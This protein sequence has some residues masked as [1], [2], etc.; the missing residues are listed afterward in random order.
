MLVVLTACVWL[1]GCTDDP[2]QSNSPMEPIDGSVLGGDDPVTPPDDPGDSGDSD[3]SDDGDA[4]GDPG[5]KLMLRTEIVHLRDP[6]IFERIRDH[7]QAIEYGHL[8]IDEERVAA[9]R[10]D[11]VE[12]F[13]YVQVFCVSLLAR[14]V[15]QG[16]Y[17]ELWNR[18]D[19]LD[20][21]IPGARYRWF[22]SEIGPSPIVDHTRSEVTH[23]L[24]DIIA[25]WT[26]GH[27]TD[28]LFIDLAREGLYDWMLW[29]G[30][31]WPWAPAEHDALNQAWR[32]NMAWLIEQQVQRFDSVAINGTYVME[33]P[34]VMYEN[35][36]WNHSRGRQSW[37]Q[38]IRR[39]QND[40]VIPMIHPGHSRMRTPAERR[41]GEEVS[42]ASW[43][44]LDKAYLV[45][46]PG[47]HQFQWLDSIV[48][49]GLDRFIATG[50]AE[51]TQPGTWT[52]EGTTPDGEV[53]R[54][55]IDA[56]GGMGSVQRV[57]GG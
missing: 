9:L 25:T 16:F 45:T 39:A 20:G 56:V 11:G 17:Q 23:G 12:V 29:P 21:W 7:Y 15:W 8:G 3:D 36:P 22:E 19:W 18:I 5:R 32:E 35:Q 37:A 53:W 14:D 33:A 1:V 30:D 38:M 34:I 4:A 2:V 52:R 47:D 48:D 43:L 26:A 13:R 31:A 27:D 40:G 10:D 41:A 51:E 46:E 6:V 57:A 28:H 49:R 44:I 50:P 54:V 55:T 24:D 42:L